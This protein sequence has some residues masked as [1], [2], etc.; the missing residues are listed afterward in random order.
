[1][2][3]ERRAQRLNGPSRRSDLFAQVLFDL[4]EPVLRRTIKVA[5]LPKLHAA[6]FGKLFELEPSP[7]LNPAE[8]GV[9]V[10]LDAL[11]LLAQQTE[12]EFAPRPEVAIQQL[13]VRHARPDC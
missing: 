5:Q 11:K 10:L 6:V 3:L 8:L 4:V 7:I 12:L 2:A 13:R 1:M 9:E